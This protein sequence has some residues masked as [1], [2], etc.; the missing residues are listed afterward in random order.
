MIITEAQGT[1]CADRPADHFQSI[2]ICDSIHADRP[3]IYIFDRLD[4][5]AE[6]CLCLVYFLSI[7]TYTLFIVWNEDQADTPAEAV[8]TDKKISPPLSA[9]ASSPI[10]RNTVSAPEATITST[11]PRPISRNPNILPWFFSSPSSRIAFSK[12]GKGSLVKI[13]KLEDVD[14][15]IT[16]AALTSDMEAAIKE[17]GTELMIVRRL[18]KGIEVSTKIFRIFPKYL[19]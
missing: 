17:K 12:F 2:L 11:I 6:G 10:R 13:C 19:V 8:T 15:I 3:D 5:S 7:F 14:M 1:S 18:L 16:D 4:H 9:A